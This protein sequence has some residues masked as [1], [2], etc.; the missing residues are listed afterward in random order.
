ML[1]EAETRPD[2]GALVLTNPCTSLNLGW[3]LSPTSWNM[4]DSLVVIIAPAC[5][6]LWNKRKIKNIIEI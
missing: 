6:N 3:V 4:V 5:R 1:L 2:V